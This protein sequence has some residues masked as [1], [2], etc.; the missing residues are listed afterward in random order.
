MK[1]LTLLAFFTCLYTCVSAQTPPPRLNQETTSL[2]FI[3]GQSSFIIDS[4][5]ISTTL[6]A[7]PYGFSFSTDTLLLDVTIFSPLDYLSVETFGGDHSFGVQRCWVDGPFANIHLSIEA[8]RGQI[9]SV[10]YSYADDWFRSRVNYLKGVTSMSLLKGTLRY[11]ATEQSENLMCAKFLSAYFELPNLSRKDL[12]GMKETAADL[13]PGKIFRHP[14][15]API[16]QK[17]KLAGSNLPGRLERYSLLNSKGEPNR[18]QASGAGFYVLNFYRFSDPVAQNHHQTIQK[19]YQQDT[20]FQNIPIVSIDT[21]KNY[22]GWRSYVENEN[23]AWPHYRS[24]QADPTSL[25]A[26]LKY[27]SS[28]FY[29]LINDRNRIEGIYDDLENLVRAMLYRQQLKPN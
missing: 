18:I 23:F 25:A 4:I 24:N 15:L 1:T 16:R 3:K 2:A 11:Y 17:I 14:W 13:F 29:L 5:T 26:K 22:P 6:D 19:V 10:A 27:S 28:P 7:I 20:L 12:K 8:G 9:D 21:E